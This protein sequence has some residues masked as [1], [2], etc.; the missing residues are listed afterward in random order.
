M[1]NKE[2]EIELRAPRVKNIIGEI[3][4]TI[5]R[6]GNMFIIGILCIIFSFAL[7]LPL[8]W[9]VS[10]NIYIDMNSDIVYIPLNNSN[11]F[12]HNYQKIN[13]EVDA[14]YTN[15]IKPIELSLTFTR[16]TVVYKN[17]LYVV[18]KFEYDSHRTNIRPIDNE[19][20]KAKIYIENKKTPLIK[21]FM[22][23]LKL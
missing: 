18:K 12:L 19:L 13:V 2:K 20:L 6:I 1:D 11:S 17:Q 15:N 7:Y 14:F 22:F 21:R 4:P 10:T 9:I 16:D 5:I 3:P 8:P 23:Y